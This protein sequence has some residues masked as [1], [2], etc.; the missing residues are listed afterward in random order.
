[1]SIGGNIMG[2]YER[3]NKR[4]AELKKLKLELFEALE[5]IRYQI[6][7]TESEIADCEGYLLELRSIDGDE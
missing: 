3:T 5:D 6:E 4:I 1:M 7:L 2:E